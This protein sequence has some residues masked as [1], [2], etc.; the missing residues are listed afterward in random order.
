[1]NFRLHLNFTFQKSNQF[2]IVSGL[3]S[4]VTKRNYN[5]SIGILI[6]VDQLVYRSIFTCLSCLMNKNLIRLYLNLSSKKI[7]RRLHLILSTSSLPTTLLSMI[8]SLNFQ[9][10]AKNISLLFRTYHHHH[11]IVVSL[12]FF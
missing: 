5:D 3:S 4:V 7:R 2:I 9:K 6:N 1:M 12:E 10:L 11:L 8:S